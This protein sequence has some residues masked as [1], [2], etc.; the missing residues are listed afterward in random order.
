MID[1]IL[2]IKP[3][4]I[5]SEHENEHEGYE[6]NKRELV[7]K[8]QAAQCFVS[9]Y[10]IPPGKSAYPYHY[11]TKREEVFYILSGSGTLKTPDGERNVAAGDFLFFPANEN[12]AHKITNTSET[13]TL[14]YLDFDT[15]NDID[16]AFYPDS[17]KI[18]I[19]G[20]NID[21]LYK[22][23]RQSEYYDDE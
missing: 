23:D 12:G 21:Q 1:R 20:K 8:G 7:A 17:G 2:H 3:A 16:V 19:W 4:D 14:V 18:G 11:H 10:E 13:K 15:Y 22:T 9:M 6:Y 5:L